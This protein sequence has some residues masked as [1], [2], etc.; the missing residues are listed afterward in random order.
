MPWLLC[1]VL[2]LA[3]PAFAQV[4]VPAQP[5]GAIALAHDE[6]SDAAIA[7]RLRGI[8][9]ELDGYEKVSVAVRAGVVT[10]AGETRDSASRDRL[11]QIVTRL[12]GVAAINNRLRAASSLADRLLPSLDRFL[13]RAQLTLAFLPLLVVAL[14]ALGGTYL[15]GRV[16]GALPLWTR[17]APNLFIGRI[18]RQVVHLI[19]LLV[20]LIVALDILDA[21]ALLG[22]ILGA[23][24]IIGLALGFAVR[25]T[26]ENFIASI[27]LSIRQPFRPFDMVEIEGDVGKVVRLTSRATILLSV[28]G[29]AI[30]VPNAIVFKAR[31]VN[32]SRN[33]ERRFTFAIDIDPAVDMAA[34]RDRAQ[35]RLAALPFVL[36]DPACSVWVDEKD[37][38][39]VE[40]HFSA[41]IDQTETSF[42]L[43]RGEAIRI[44][45]AM[46]QE[47]HALRPPPIS[48]IYQLVDEEAAMNRG[49]AAPNDLKDDSIGD[50]SSSE[51]GALE[52]LAR[53]ERAESES[54]DL[55][56]RPSPQE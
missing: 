56:A 52:R 5:D 6:N 55:L 18:Y 37:G 24:G 20:G 47:E 38:S 15:L 9:A 22:S 16:V 53:V 7:A 17:V 2:G 35:E 54:R 14:L 45:R 11:A 50:L 4:T 21:T 13:Q 43:A 25:D 10:L 26:V 3:L 36:A 31:I 23:A 19:F 39:D 1:L 42:E 40:L 32:F 28:D 44:L 41:W 51:A 27:M 33:P 34:L 46:L 29:N 48:R 30:R 8:L 49:R 12:E